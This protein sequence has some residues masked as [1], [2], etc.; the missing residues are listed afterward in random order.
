M[1]KQRGTPKQIAKR[2]E[3]KVESRNQRTPYRR[4]LFWLSLFAVLGSAAAIYYAG[5]RAPGEF[6]NTGPLSR[7]HSS[8][9]NDCASC[10]QAEPLEA[11]RFMQVVND[12][13]RHGAPSIARIDHACQA[14]HTQHAFHEPNVVENRSCSACHTEHQGPGPMPAVTNVDCA[15]CHN[16]A[17]I[18]QAS[19]QRGKQVPPSHFRL[20]PKVV[21]LTNPQQNVLQL[22]RPADGYTA[23]FASFSEGHPP[24]QLQRENVREADVLR[25]NHQLHMGGRGIPPTRAGG[26]LDCN[27]CHKPEPTGRYMQRV[28]FEANCQECHS[29]QFDVKNPDFQ[30]PHGDAQLVRTFLRTLPAQYGELARRK[31]GITDES[32][33]NAFTAQQITG[34]LTQFSTAD[35]LERTVF[36]TKDPYSTAAQ[37][38]SP[39]RAKYA[40]C[41][42]CH[43]VK[44]TSV[45]SFPMP[46]ITA[47]VVID[48]WL[49]RGHFNHAKHATVDCR[50]C[51]AA[52]SSSLTSD[53]LMPTKESCVSCHSPAGVA[54]NASECMTCHTYHAPDPRPA[55]AATAAAG[56]FKQ[57]LLSPAR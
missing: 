19:A 17:A 34:L 48:R 5:E 22:A 55:G 15:S 27:Y 50:T 35:Q 46:Q 14:C 4:A 41:A 7:H 2:Y 32:R 31:R 12:R 28:T 36:F 13:F 53:V 9:E 24:F 45:G 18:M 43:E 1:D 11:G 44:Q 49:A 38:D 3:D 29:L 30:I 37:Q 16:D 26:K 6:F 52:E 20:N 8:L 23:T 47:P 33:V 39:T 54:A 57:M 56:S 21:N 42:Y 25:F 51:H 10:H 40:G